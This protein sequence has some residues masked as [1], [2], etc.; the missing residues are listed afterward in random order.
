MTSRSITRASICL[1]LL[2]SMTPA[3]ADGV[4]PLAKLAGSWS[5]SGTAKFE[6]GQ[7]EKLECR[8]HFTIKSGESGMGLALRCAS[9]GAKIDMRSLLAVDN[10]SVSGTWE[11]RTFNASGNLAGKASSGSLSLVISGGGLAGSMSMTFSQSSQSVHFTTSGTALRS[12]SIRL[13]RL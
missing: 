6:G 8:G 13:N 1:A 5:G 10:G 11:E 9:A 4:G 3:R 2:F 12:A 7:S